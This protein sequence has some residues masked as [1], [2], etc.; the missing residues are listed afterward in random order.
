MHANRIACVVPGLLC[1]V[2]ICRLQRTNR[3]KFRLLITS[4]KLIVE[5]SNG[6]T[7]RLLVSVPAGESSAV[8]SHRGMLQ[9]Y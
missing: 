7:S 9:A 1:L 2:G 4:L 5:S 6:D 3:D 8:V